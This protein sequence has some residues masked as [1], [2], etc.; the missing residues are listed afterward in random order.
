VNGRPCS[1]APDPAAPLPQWV[2]LHFPQTIRFNTAQLTFQLAQ[3]APAG[4][5]LSSRDA[6]RWATIV[7][8][9]DNRHR[10]RLHRFE[11]VSSDALRLTIDRRQPGAPAGLCPVCEIRLYDRA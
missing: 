3:L 2:E 5:T 6:G 7:Q 1:W 4:Y 11:P 10:R 8:V 9:E